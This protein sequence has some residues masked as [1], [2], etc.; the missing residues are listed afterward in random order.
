MKVSLAKHSMYYRQAGD[1]LLQAVHSYIDPFDVAR[2]FCHFLYLLIVI[3]SS[4]AAQPLEQ[5]KWGVW[6]KSPLDD[7]FNLYPMPP[8]SWVMKTV[9]GRR[10]AA[11]TGRFAKMASGL[12][13]Q[14]AQ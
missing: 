5:K 7:R 8:P 11:S 14:I 10:R 6:N 2:S 3:S 1:K 4:V 9:Y 12:A 13:V